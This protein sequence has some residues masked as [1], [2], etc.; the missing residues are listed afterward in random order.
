[1]RIKQRARKGK[2][3]F[4]NKQN[5]MLCFE[6]DRDGGVY[7]ALF[8][9]LVNILLRRIQLLPLLLRFDGRPLVF[10][11]LGAGHSSLQD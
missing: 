9:F 6:R 10:L 8:R 2:V 4:S 11:L 3:S 1:M 5:A 7:R